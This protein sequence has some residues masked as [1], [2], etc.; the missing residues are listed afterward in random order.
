MKKKWFPV[1][2][3]IVCCSLM[4]GCMYPEERKVQ[5]QIPYEDQVMAVQSAVEK[6]QKDN[7]GILPIKNKDADTPIYQKYLIDFNKLTPTY[8]PEPPGNSLEGGGI[9]Q[10]VLVDVEENP[11]V[12]IFDLRIAE[13][14]RDIKLRIQLK[15][16]FPPYKEKINDYLFK[17]D[18][19]KIGFKEDP[20]V[21]SPYSDKDLSFI[22]SADGEIYVDYLPDLHEALQKYDHHFKPGDDIREILVQNTLFVPAYSLPYTINDQTGKIDYMIQK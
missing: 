22:V 8:M 18:F 16:G 21:K 13:T 3:L 5:N 2:L 11:T 19:S 1:L 6:F 17:L 7:G 14:I 20:V 12:K 4:T 9:F 15:D 10:Y